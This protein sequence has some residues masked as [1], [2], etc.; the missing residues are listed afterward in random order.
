[1]VIFI[2]PKTIHYC[3]FGKS[4][5]P[6]LVLKCIDSWRKFLPD[7]E[8]KEWNENCFDINCNKY[9]KQAYDCKKYA[10]VSDYA[11]FWV[12]YNFGGL[13]FDTDVEVIKPFGDLL[14]N[15][16]FAGHETDDFVAPGLVLWS[17]NKGNTIIGE[18]LDKYANIEFIKNDGS[19]NTLT[20]CVYFTE[21]LKKH[22]FVRGNILQKCGDFTIYPIDWFCP[23]NDLTGLLKITENTA[24]IH[25]YHKTWMSKRQV[26]K[27][28]FT[29]IIHRVF[30]VYFFLNLK[31][32]IKK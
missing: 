29:R 8:I 3:W 32:K 21:V 15:D 25:W 10:C 11:R 22:G 26:Y 6:K 4:E 17:K 28:K 24:A 14:S 2:N 31:N 5:K 13:Y 16:A 19:F 9:V 23:F 1:M 12:L 20:V 30:G 7:F 27:N 18:M